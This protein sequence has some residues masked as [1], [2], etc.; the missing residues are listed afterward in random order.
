ML[1]MSTNVTVLLN[2]LASGEEAVREELW[3]TLYGEL[4]QLAAGLLA[5]EQAGQTIQ[6]TALIHEAYLRLVGSDGVYANRRYFFGAA[7]QAMRRILVDTA[8]RKQSLKGGGEVE[9]V[10]WEEPAWTAK[11]PPAEVLAIHEALERLQSEDATVAEVVNLHFFAGFSLEETAEA[12]DISRATAYR[13]WTYA[14]AW[15]REA[16]G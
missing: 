9:Q 10:P 11:L 7:A 12:L 2:Q 3:R 1:G 6:P 4:R 16:L 13:N 14:R 15:L 5:K 8:R